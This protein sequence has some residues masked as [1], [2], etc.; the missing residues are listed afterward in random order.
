VSEHR[1]IATAAGRV[2]VVFTDRADGDFHLDGD[3]AR[4]DAV[5]RAVVDLPWSWVRQVHGTE[6]VV[7]ERPGD[8]AGRDGDGLVTAVPGA[9]L[10][11]RGADCPVVALVS[12]EGVIGVAHA[13]WRGLV[14][15]VL[16]RT[17]EAM[18]GR[19]ATGV[20]GYLG[21]CITA[22]RYEFGE[23]D[24]ELA[25]GRLGPSVRAR[26]EWGT[27]ALD[28]V[29][30]VTV[31]LQRCGVAVDLSGHRCT[32][33]DPAYFSHRARREHG[34]HAAAVWLAPS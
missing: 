17:V 13:G 27:P 29:A 10:S 26:T 25:A 3:P 30:G 12:P 34:R 21:P 24:L 19:G 7:V 11:V 2:H 20:A 23:A 32:A 16:E 5:A 18:R 33:T 9:V 31:A 6:V 4:R 14:A 22:G 1:E 28:L 8:G 15:G